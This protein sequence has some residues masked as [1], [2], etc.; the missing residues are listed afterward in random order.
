VTRNTAQQISFFN[1]HHFIV[2][3]DAASR[4]GPP[5]SHLTVPGQ[6]HTT[7][8]HYTTPGQAFT[9]YSSYNTHTVG[10]SFQVDLFACE[11]SRVKCTMLIFLA[12]YTDCSNTLHDTLP[13]W[14]DSEDSCC[15]SVC[16]YFCSSC[17]RHPWL[18]NSP[19]KR[20]S[21]V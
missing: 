15:S 16:E 13:T 8:G 21:T 17:R 5:A 6:N 1:F 11:I 2:L 14:N 19:A 12:V 7:P 3:V 10:H 4:L 18:Q 20:A 9:P